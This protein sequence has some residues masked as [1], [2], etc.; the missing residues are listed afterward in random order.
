[1]QVKG[2]GIGSSVQMGTSLQS[3]IVVVQWS[4]LNV[5]IVVQILE[6]SSISY[7]KLTK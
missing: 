2:K 6:D 5:W 4:Y 1:M 7:Y 3:E